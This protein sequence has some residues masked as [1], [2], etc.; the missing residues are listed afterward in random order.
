MTV[1]QLGS[2]LLNMT[3]IENLPAP[4]VYS[5]DGIYLLEMITTESSS[6]I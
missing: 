4:F 2:Y 5:A 6:W 1:Q 3:I